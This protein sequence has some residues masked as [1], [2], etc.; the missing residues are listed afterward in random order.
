M[1]NIGRFN[2]GAKANIVPKETSMDIS[3]R[4]FDSKTRGET[5]HEAIKR[6]AKALQICIK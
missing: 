6:Y 1:L 3:M 5:E 4:Y 2:S